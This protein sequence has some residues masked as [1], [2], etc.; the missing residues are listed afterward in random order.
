MKNLLKNLTNKDNII[1]LVLFIIYA[2]F[3][4]IL[5]L[6]HEIWADEAQVWL[7]VRDLDLWGIIRH[8]RTEG[9]P[10]VWYFLILPFAKLHLPVISMQIF[11]WL[12]T[13]LGAGIF[14]FKAPFK[15]YA[16]YSV[17]LSSVFL[18]WLPAIARSY[19][20]IPVLLFGLAILYKKQKEHPYL[21]AVL[22]VLLANTHVIMFG[23]CTALAI[24]FLIDNRE[25]KYLVPVTLAILGVAG[26]AG[27]LYG[28]QSENVIVNSYTGSFS[29]EYLKEIY[30]KVVFN[31]YGTVNAFVSLLFA[32][33]IIFT[34]A[35]VYLNNKKIFFVYLS[36]LIW[37]FAIFIFI[38]GI[39][40]QRAYALLLV[41]IFC[42]WEVYSDILKGKLTL[43]ILISL[44]FISSLPN[45]A[46]SISKEFR[47]VFSDGKNTAEFIKNNIPENAFIL[48]NYPVRTSSVSVY[49]PKDKWKFYYDSYE[50][51]YTYTIWNKPILPSSASLDLVH[52]I[53]KYGEIYVIM[54]NGSFY[55]DV[56]PIYKSIDTALTDKVYIYKFGNSK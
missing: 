55:E 16:K 17:L 47:Y 35:I 34:G 22:I 26:C 21:Y 52:Y 45:S 33:F 51:F 42:L 7:V 25:K 49:L 3:T 8:V 44:I 43:N 19:C 39:L 13:V 40:P 20:L 2:V 12:L 30:E 24:L 48:S 14:L 53:K 18:Y 41:C 4:L 5:V 27:Y 9:H 54:S 6:H 46:D 37:Q 1:S 29:F 36:N 56:E 32:V 38:W 11:N 23:F 31:L 28:S 15:A 50:D 10:L